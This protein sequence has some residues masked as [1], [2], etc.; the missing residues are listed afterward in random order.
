MET[1]R[2]FLNTLDEALEQAKDDLHFIS[3][4]D[5][6]NRATLENVDQI[7]DEIDNIQETITTIQEDNG[8]I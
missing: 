7:Y 6:L 3:F 4:R 2:T 1:L 5:N 8:W